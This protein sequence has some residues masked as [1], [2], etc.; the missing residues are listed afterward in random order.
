MGGGE[1]KDST[2]GDISGD[3]ENEGKNKKAEV[4][5][6]DKGK[7][8]EIFGSG[9]AF[10]S[11]GG[12]IETGGETS[13]SEKSDDDD[14]EKVEEDA[15]DW[16]ITEGDDGDENDSVAEEEEIEELEDDMAEQIA[17]RFSISDAQSR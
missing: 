3:E 12:D 4:I 1:K 17:K 10:L 15:I 8:K 6:K 9:N 13:E 16:S 7:D 14:D 5:P 11:E 2:E